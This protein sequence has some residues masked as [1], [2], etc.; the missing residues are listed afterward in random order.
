[1]RHALAVLVG[2]A[3]ALGLA[4]PAAAGE[5][6][7]GQITVADAGVNSNWTLVDGGAFYVAPQ[8]LITVQPNANAYVCI[9]TLTA[10]RA[11]TCTAITG[12]RVDANVAFPT[13]CQSTT[14]QVLMPDAGLVQ[15]C[16]IAILPVT[17]ATVSASVWQRRGNEY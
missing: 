15:G 2:F 4:T 1:M 13:S 6:F 11:P 10:T 16:T 14:G 8:S 12:V 7:L 5:S 3:V 17:G 9:D